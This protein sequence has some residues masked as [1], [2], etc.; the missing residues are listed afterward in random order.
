[1]YYIV[2]DLEFN[3]EI[4]S[5]RST[6]IDSYRC[7]FEIIQ[8]G[9][10]KIDSSFNTVA[11]FNRYVK[12]TIYPQ[13]NAFITELT[14]ITT[15]QLLLEASFSNIFDD[16]IEFIEE[17]EDDCVFCT[18]GMSDMKEL[19]RNAAY[20]QLD[21]SRLP[22][23]FINLQPYVSTHLGLSHSKLLNLKTAIESLEISM[24]Y[25]FHNALYDAYYTA[26]LFK[27]INCP[28]LQP[29]RYDPNY[30]KIRPKQTKKIID[31]EQLI[32]QFEKMYDRELSNEEKDMIKLAYKMGKTHQF[33]K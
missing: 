14:G 1:M 18:W 25:P 9:A 5:P 15:E 19:F 3:Q 22:K 12:P 33:L 2:F 21:N 29:K 24:P 7:P 8:I 31:F 20:H 17:G 27:K 6:D 4:S 32:L 30:I 28:S 10:I 23:L 26:E 16:F 11:T 13:V